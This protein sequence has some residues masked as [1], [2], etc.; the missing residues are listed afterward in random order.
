VNETPT[1]TQ[2][3]NALRELG[4]DN[5]RIARALGGRVEQ[6]AVESSRPEEEKAA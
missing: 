5:A 1:L 3:V 4:L 2:L 6:G